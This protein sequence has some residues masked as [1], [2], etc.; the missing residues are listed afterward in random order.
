VK[1]GRSIV[2]RERLTRRHAVVRKIAR[3]SPDV[4]ASLLAPS[5][6]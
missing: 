1:A 6:R 5:Q 3:L 2:A 4:V